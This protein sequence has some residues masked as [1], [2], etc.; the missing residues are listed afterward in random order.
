MVLMME[1]NHKGYSNRETWAVCSW[2]KYDA[3][4]NL[5]ARSLSS[6]ELKFYVETLRDIAHEGNRFLQTMMDDIG[7]LWRVNWK[8]VYESCHNEPVEKDAV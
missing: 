7:S 8:Q 1:S 6:E 4:L 3:T 5:Q 2:L